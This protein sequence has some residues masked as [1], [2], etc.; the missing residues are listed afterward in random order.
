MVQRV[1]SSS[2][3]IW[4][5]VDR[6]LELLSIYGLCDSVP[7]P[8]WTV[9]DVLPSIRHHARSIGISDDATFRIQA[10]V[11]GGLDD[12]HWNWFAYTKEEHSGQPV[13]RRGKLT[14]LPDTFAPTTL[15]ENFSLGISTRELPEWCSGDCVDLTLHAELVYLVADNDINSGLAVFHVPA[16][17]KSSPAIPT[18]ATIVPP[19]E[20]FNLF[21]DEGELMFSR[22][23]R[24][25]SLVF[26]G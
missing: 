19:D 4:L 20:I 14:E 17:L 9:W 8:T 24:E 12:V 16:V 13:I 2:A 5:D 22:R 23:P 18:G 11:D 21:G 6:R 25:E 26:G 10:T 7:N 3:P 15:C 1:V